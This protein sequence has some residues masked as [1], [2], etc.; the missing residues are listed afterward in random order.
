MRNK[1]LEPRK[2]DVSA[3][4]DHVERLA[5]LSCAAALESTDVIERLLGGRVDSDKIGAMGHS[6]GSATCVRFVQDDKRCKAVVALDPW[7]WPMSEDC[8]EG[9]DTPLLIISSEFWDS[10]VNNAERR[11]KLVKNSH[12]S[13]YSIVVKDTKHHNFDDLPL[14]LGVP[15][16]GAKLGFIGEQDPLV[17]FAAITDLTRL[18]FNGALLGTSGAGEEALLHAVEQCPH[19]HVEVASEKAG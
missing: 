9:V 10:A 3:V 15:S 12:G 2:E 13:S 4:F 5:D 1:G 18:F 17:G 14:L 7:L 11:H 16:I 8:E 19:V 6:Y